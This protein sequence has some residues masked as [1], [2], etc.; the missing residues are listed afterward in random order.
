[1]APIITEIYR[2]FFQPRR[3]NTAKEWDGVQL[4][5]GKPVVAV[6]DELHHANRKTFRVCFLRG[7]KPA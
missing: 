7:G 3:K 2:V 4:K 1:M 5:D 6:E